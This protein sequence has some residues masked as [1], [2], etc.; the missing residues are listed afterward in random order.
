[1]RN[2]GNGLLRGLVLILIIAPVM[3]AQAATSLMGVEHAQSADGGVKIYLKTSGDQP[4]VSVFATESPAA[5]LGPS[6]RRPSPK[7]A[8]RG[9]PK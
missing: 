5:S 2:L 6:S 9:A 3:A 8:R 1:M 4:Q 7:I